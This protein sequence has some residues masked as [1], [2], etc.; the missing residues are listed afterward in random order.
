MQ[1]SSPPNFV[2]HFSMH[3]ALCTGVSSCWNRFG[4]PEMKGNFPFTSYE[5]LLDNS[6]VATICA[7]GTLGE[8]PYKGF[9]GQVSSYF[10][11]HIQCV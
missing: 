1:S 10:W 2:N 8:H 5:D 6:E 9:D 11:P 7:V 3:S 4:A